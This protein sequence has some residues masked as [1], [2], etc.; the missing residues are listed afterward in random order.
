MAGFDGHLMKPVDIDAVLKLVEFVE[1]AP[2]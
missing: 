2:R 1:I